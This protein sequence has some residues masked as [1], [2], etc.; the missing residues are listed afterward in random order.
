MEYNT[1][2]AIDIGTTK[3]ATVVIKYSKPGNIEILGGQDDEGRAYAE[4]SST[5]LLKAVGEV[6]PPDSPR[7]N[8]R[9]VRSRHPGPIPLRKRPL[10]LPHVPE[11]LHLRQ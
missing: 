3:I 5:N 4:P 1:I 2:T 9:Q 11:T 7:E 6:V 10:V 8:E